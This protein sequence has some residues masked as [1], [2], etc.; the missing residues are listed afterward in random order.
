MTT[1]MRYYTALEPMLRRLAQNPRVDAGAMGEANQHLV[2]LYRQILEFQIRSV[3]R[4]FQGALR[5]F[6]GDVFQRD[7]WA[8]MVSAA[9][10]RE[11]EVNSEP[12]QIN[13][14]AL[15]PGPGV[16]G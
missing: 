16:G 7:T 15:R 8:S 5:K 14:L 1:R 9:R 13:A 4:F 11:A 6:A 12:L 2:A 3:I 10:E